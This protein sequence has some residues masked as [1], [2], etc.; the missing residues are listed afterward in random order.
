[1]L[2]RVIAAAAGL[3]VLLA[4]VW[5][6]TP[7]LT[8][9]V[10]AA[11]ILGLREFYRLFNTGDVPLP[12]ALGSLWALAFLVAQQL[13]GAPATFLAASGGV[14]VVGCL[15]GV[16]WMIGSYRGRLPLQALVFLVLGPLII[17]FS[18]AHALALRE[19]GASD[20]LGRGWLLF[21]MLVTFASDTGAFFVGR[22]IGRHPMAPVISPNKTWEGA[23]GGFLAAV[24][25]A[26][27]LA[28]LFGLSIPLWQSFLAGAVIGIAAQAGDLAESK[29]KRISQVKDAGSIIPGHGGILDRLDSLSLSIPAAFYIAWFTAA[30]GPGN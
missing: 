14:T 5:F 28:A 24:L 10:A 23:V 8:L 25:A 7:W 26:V 4:A 12:L 21:A 11:A 29:L 30:A 17:G 3:P 9:L 13:S 15:A 27:V 20:A 2:P 16:L 1:M 6:G 22:A 19:F 18:L